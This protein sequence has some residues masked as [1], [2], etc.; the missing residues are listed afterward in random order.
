MEKGWTHQRGRQDV[1]E[2]GD[3]HL[4]ERDQAVM[5]RNI[6][7]KIA[8]CLSWCLDPLVDPGKDIGRINM[9]LSCSMS[10]HHTDETVIPLGQE[11][12][13]LASYRIGLA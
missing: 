13:A 9:F 2:V 8:I 10:S 7:I 5:E 3:D 11:E 12:L 1:R 4:P 6:R